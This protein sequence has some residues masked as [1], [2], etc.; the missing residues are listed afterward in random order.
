M[1]YRDLAD[2]ISTRM[3][4]SHIY[5]PVMLLTLLEN[6]GIASDEKIAKAILEYD[7]SQLEYYIKIVHNMVGRVLRRHGVV[8]KN[9]LSYQ[10]P[11]FESISLSERGDL[12]HRC[13]EKLAD[14]ILKRGERIWKHRKLSDGYISGTLRYEVL[15]RA[16][17]HCELCGIPADERALEVDHIVPRNHGGTDDL[18]NFQALCYSCNSMKRDRDDTDFR[19]VKASYHLKA[20]GCLF[21]DL[22][23][24]RI[25]LENSLA[26]VIDDQY[27]VT[28]SHSL[29]IPKRHV[30]D[31]FGLS[32]PEIN[33][34]NQLL[35]ELKT[36]IEHGDDR[37]SGFNIGM[38]SGEAAGQTIFHCH[39]H[40]IPRRFGDVEN[41]RG[42]V[43]H[44]IPG[45]G[46]Y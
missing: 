5:Q 41:P 7:Q 22:P 36:G 33:A 42:G 18:H 8:E 17:F 43:R 21:C 12:I 11:D 35:N 24:D 20:D 32:Q 26:M 40:L 13:R 3:R 30:R 44:L 1:N 37:V 39:I 34:C 6:N 27:P 38:N 14:Y 2:F 28:E 25:V 29:I 4:M 45:K 16:Q 9:G 46:H 10:L 31:Y 19:A 23:K 15:K